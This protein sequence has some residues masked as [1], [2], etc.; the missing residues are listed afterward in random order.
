MRSGKRLALVV[1]ALLAL[2]VLPGSASA[3]Q[4]KAGAWVED[5]TWHVGASAGQ[6]A[7]GDEL[8]E[9][10]A[11]GAFANVHSS[12]PHAHSTR[13]APSYGVQSRLSV[14][15][16]VVQ[17]TDDRKFALVKNDLYIPQDLLWRRAAQI[18]EGKGIG[19]DRNNL[20]MAVTHNHSSPMYSSTGWGVWVFQDVFDFRFFEYMAKKMATAVEKANN[21][22]VPVKVGAS[23]SQYDFVQRNVPGPSTA[24]DNSPAGF[25]NDYTD[26]D[27][28]VVRFDRTDGRGTVAN[29]VNYAVHPEDNEGNDLISADYLGP[30]ERMA[31]RATGA[32]TIFTQGAVG[33]TEPEDNRWHDIHQRAYFS[34]GQ[35]AQSEFKAR[36]IAG[37]IVDTF[38]DVAANT[39]EDP[40]RFAPFRS[41]FANGD[42]QFRDRWFPGPASHPYPGI[43][44]CRTDHALAGDPRYPIVGFP[45]CNTLNETPVGEFVQVPTQDTGIRTDN[46][47]E[48]G[49]PVPENYSAPSYT[50]LEE[51]VSVHLQAFRIGDILLTVCSC[52]QWAD[53][54]KNIKSRTDKVAGNQHNGYDWTTNCVDIGGDQWRCQHPNGPLTISTQVK[55][56][57]HAQ[58]N[59]DA[60]G[61]DA[62][63]YVAQAESE[64]TNP[65]EIKGNYSHD[66]FGPSAEAG[67]AL[68][69]AIG[70]ANDYNG[71]IATYR[72]Y[73]RGDHYRK[74]LTAWGPHSSDYMATRLVKMGRDLKK[75][76]D[77][78]PTVPGSPFNAVLGTT[79]GEWPGGDAKVTADLAHNEGRARTIG[80]LANGGIAAY[81]ASLPDDRAAKVVRQ[82]D[83]VERFG[84]AAFTWVGGSNYTDSPRVEVERFT[85]GNWVPYADQTGELPITLKFPPS[86]DRPAYRVQGSEFQWTAHFEAFVS[87]YDLMDRPLSTPAGSYRFV[88]R[89]Q[90]QQGG[91]PADYKLTSREFLVK[92]WTGVSIESLNADGGQPAFKV[93]PRRTIDCQPD[94]RTKI[95]A[96]LGPI[97]YPDTW[98][99]NHPAKIPFITPDRR[100][101]R[102]PA[103]LT[104]PERF[105]WY[106]RPQ[107]GTPHGCSFRPWL[108]V[109]DLDRVVFTIVAANGKVDR[110]AGKKVGGEWV[111]DRKLRS[112]EGVYVEAGDACD[113][114]GNY[115]GKASAQVGNK[116]AVPDKP[117]A[118]F[119][120]VPKPPAGDVPGESAPGGG[121]GGGSGSGTSGV[122]G[123][124]PLGLPDPKKTCLDRRRFSFKIHQ[125]PRRRVVA[126]NVFV[127][128]KRKLSRRG[129]KITR[130]TIK[131]L[132]SSTKTYRVRIIALTNRGDRIISDRRY[133]G[134]KK[135]RPTTRV[136]S[137]KRKKKKSARG[138]R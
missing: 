10:D 17:G 104:D 51:D 58:V 41:E 42:V 64:P 26:H 8:N 31:D 124:N 121:P 30:T 39:P 50:G 73:Q 112:G 91:K 20:T 80:E 57:V 87:R 113:A 135:G 72:E 5:A 22:M 23:V 79:P 82:P 54:S 95:P 105:E 19:I 21:A 111:A 134:C 103:A 81:E 69:V 12:D 89:G 107:S 98:Q 88:V 35:Y 100:C 97:D 133:K 15:A 123:S 3:G 77:S 24:D 99:A 13:R 117:P 110:V 71:Y 40:G 74:A 136:E 62:L 4:I 76:T 92:P 9:E 137:K 46:L 65:G 34:H 127:N 27:L 131:K 28:I 68:T 6:Y 86:E 125:P 122:S 94:S 29:L 106:C 2:L 116:D 63:S 43:S 59:N 1:A 93:G 129:S 52:E 138:R 44:S 67:Y 126:V 61:W 102:D 70:M 75:G 114:Y 128:G 85:G 14:R 16:L 49:I 25:P 45:D 118:G 60:T 38:K 109:G 7:S 78:F 33:N 120:C 90:R 108:D 119:S 55:N 66:D 48:L 53:Q 36:G 115:N 83:D 84:A 130:V 56:K 11:G 132:P 96:R 101:Y 18:L 37:A 47:Q 32:P